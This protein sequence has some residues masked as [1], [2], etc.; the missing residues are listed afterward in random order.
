MI[1]GVCTARSLSTFSKL[2]TMDPPGDIT[3][4][5]SPPERS[6]MPDSF[7]LQFTKMPTMGD[8][9]PLGR[10]NWTDSLGPSVQRTKQPMG[11]LSK[12]CIWKGMS[13]A[14]ELEH[15]AYRPLNYANF[16]LKTGTFTI[17][18]VFP[19]GTVEL[20]QNSGPNFKVNGHRLKHYFGWDIP[21]MDIP[22]LQTFSKDN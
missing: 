19:Y 5:I 12:A 9:R 7:G 1:G 20:S 21:A 8:K 18:Q 6:L 10:T 3:V 17:V 15:K 14:I 11:A 4:Q 13:S 22:D 16:D 2:A